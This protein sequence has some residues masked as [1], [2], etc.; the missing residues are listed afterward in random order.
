MIQMAMLQLIV[1]ELILKR[2]RVRALVKDIKSATVG[3]GAYVEVSAGL[4]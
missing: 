3:F 1:L 2:L 4:R